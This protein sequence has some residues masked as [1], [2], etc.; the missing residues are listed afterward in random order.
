[1][2]HCL[3]LFALLALVGCSVN[4]AT[5]KRQ[6]TALMSEAKERQIG[7]E[8]HPKA[9]A[10]FGGEIQNKK[11][12]AYV[13]DLGQQL[14]QH[15]ERPDVRYTFTT[16][17]SPVVNAF[18]IPGGYIY[19]TRGILAL[20]NDEAEL[21]GVIGHEIGHI[22]GRHS[23][24][25]Y[26]QSLLVGLGANVASAVIDVPGA[27]NALGLGSQLVLTSYSRE[28]EREADR[29]GVRYLNREG[30]QPIAMADFLAQLQRDETY[31]RSLKD[32]D[33]LRSG[34]GLD[35]Y[36]RTHPLTAERV[37]NATQEAKQYLN[38]TQRNRDKYLSVIDGMVYGP[39]PKEGFVRGQ[40]FLHPDLNFKFTAPDGFE[41][42]NQP[43][44]VIVKKDKI[45]AQLDIDSK[46]KGIDPLKYLQTWRPNGVEQWNIEPLNVNGFKGANAFADVFV[47]NTP[48]ILRNVALLGPKNNMF[49]FQIIT[50]S[51]LARSSNSELLTMVNSF[52]DL[53]QN[54]REV[55]KPHFIKIVTAKSGQ[56]VRDIA[57]SIPDIYKN[58]ESLFRTL[59]GMQVDETLIAGRKYK[60]I[61]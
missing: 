26:S 49:R 34:G 52:D 38:F 6:F 53:T 43:N 14:A 11:I 42:I 5:G 4:P 3:Y 19:I 23:A 15:T 45:I 17:D 57:N 28:Q 7:A 60:T 1:M 20:A 37:Q 27:G 40:D 21:A 25:R 46:A 12:S 31:Q 22:T 2:K 13:N 56:S 32:G 39:S 41:I 30:Y 9:I 16:L 50:P 29:L 48:A 36:F 10:S 18:A 24:E 61:R 44:A 47:Q 33:S 35:A 59:N 51:N 54:D 58:R 8:S 55:A